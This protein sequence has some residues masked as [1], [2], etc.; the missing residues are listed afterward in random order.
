MSNPYEDEARRRPKGRN[1]KPL[2]QLTPFLGRYKLQMVLALVALLAAAI[3]TLTVPVAVRRVID[4]GF[5]ADNV[6]LVNQYFVVML[7]VVLVLAVGSAT[8]FYFVMWLGER[9]VADIRDAVFSHLLHLSPSFYETQRTGEVLS[10][11]TADTTQIKSAF[12]STASIALRNL[13]ML[14]GTVAMMVYTSPRLAGLSLLAIPLVV[15]P[16]VIYGRKVRSLSREA[17]DDAGQFGRLRPGAA[18]R[19]DHGAVQRAG[20]RQPVRLC[21]GHRTGLRRGRP[22]HLR[23]RRADGRHHQRGA[24]FHRA[25]ALVWRQRSPQ[26]QSHQ[27]HAFA[28]S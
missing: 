14:I 21:G 18:Q 12:S 9:V 7:A 6:E 26:R 5:I 27:R 28:S 8:R 4:N 11:L 1:L 24:R 17:Q 25:A 13:V 16:L 2:L 23:P 20:T 19:H 15:L 22:P 3:A 10:R